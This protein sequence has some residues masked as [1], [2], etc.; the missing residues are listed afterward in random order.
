MVE[1]IGRTSRSVVSLLLFV[2]LAVGSACGGESVGHE[3]DVVGG[4]CR[5]NADCADQCLRGDDFPDG[6]CSVPCR[7]DFDCPSGT[8]CIDT[9]GGVCLLLCNFDSDCR[10]GYDCDD[11]S[12]RGH[13]GDATVCID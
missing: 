7:D 4:P 6:T 8:A 1:S 9:E 2:G 12:R 11:E 5:D 13:P 10:R 3:G